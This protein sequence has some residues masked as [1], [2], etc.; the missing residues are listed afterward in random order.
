[1]RVDVTQGKAVQ[2][3][4][5]DDE[6][7]KTIEST[8]PGL[9]VSSFIVSVWQELQDYNPSGERHNFSG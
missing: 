7:L 6:M 9:G 1:M 5:E 3:M 8:Y 2:V 4:N